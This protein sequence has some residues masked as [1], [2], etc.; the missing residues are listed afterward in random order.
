MVFCVFDAASKQS[1]PRERDPEAEQREGKPTLIMLPY[2]A[3]I[4]ER[5]RLGRRA[6]TTT[7][8]WCLDLAQPSDLYSLRSETLSQPRNKRT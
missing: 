5:I 1:T 7:S 4:N 6:G 8:E 2:V 3:G